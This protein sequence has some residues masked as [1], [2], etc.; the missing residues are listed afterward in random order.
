M[1][2]SELPQFAAWRHVTARDGFEVAFIHAGAAGVR[3]EGHTNAIEAGEPFAVRYTIVLDEHGRTRHARIFG[4]SRSGCHEVVVETDGEGRWRVDGVAAP[5]LDGC[6]D[7]DLESSSLTNAFPVRRLGLAV[8]G[9]I[10][11]APAVYVRALDL[12]VERLEQRYRRIADDASGPRF[13]YEAPAFATHC[14]IRYDGSG[15]AI[16]YPGI[17][18]RVG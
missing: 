17:A 14:V 3:F 18:T 8:D 4:S 5:T 16:D 12:R 11:D 2:F 6:F 10:A 9:A 15:L 1:A 13:E 7:V